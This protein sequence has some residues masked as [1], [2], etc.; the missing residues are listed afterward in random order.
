MNVFADTV[1]VSDADSLPFPYW[2]GVYHHLYSGVGSSDRAVLGRA[3]EEIRQFS[4]TYSFTASVALVVTWER[5]RQ[6]YVQS[7]K[8]TSS[9]RFWYNR[10]LCKCAWFAFAVSK[11]GILSGKINANAPSHDFSFPPAFL[12]SFS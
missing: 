6:R 3:T 10:L 4:G 9:F 7:A 12:F 11:W 5:V 1:S 8:V 2:P